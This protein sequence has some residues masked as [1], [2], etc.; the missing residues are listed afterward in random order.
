MDLELLVKKQNDNRSTFFSAGT[1]S[2][3]TGFSEIA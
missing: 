2:S 3:D 1:T